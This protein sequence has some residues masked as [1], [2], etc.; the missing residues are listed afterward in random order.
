[1]VPEALTLLTY[2]RCGPKL[3][4][5]QEMTSSTLPLPASS[6]ILTPR[7]RIYRIYYNQPGLA[8]ALAQYPQGIVV[9]TILFSFWVLRFGT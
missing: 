8:V 1:M 3:I 4:D 5:T 9:G 6:A 2:W 7:G